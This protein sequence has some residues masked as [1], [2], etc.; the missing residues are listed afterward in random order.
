MAVPVDYLF[1]EVPNCSKALTHEASL[2]DN[3]C[4]ALKNMPEMD[5]QPDNLKGEI[6]DLLFNSAEINKFAPR[7]RAEYIKDMTTLRDITNQFATAEQKGL[8]K[9]RTEV[10]IAIAQNLLTMEYPIET[11]AQ[12]TGLTPEDITALQ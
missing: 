6:F 9:G 10:R 12:V 7:E 11:I 2:L 8:E 3:L 5:C 1:L 4:Y